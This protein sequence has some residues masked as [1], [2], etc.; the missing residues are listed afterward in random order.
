MPKVLLSDDILEQLARQEFK[1]YEALKI[2]PP[3]VQ[4]QLDYPSVPNMAVGHSIVA[5]LW[6]KFPGSTSERVCRI[7][8]VAGFNNTPRIFNDAA[9]GGLD[10]M[11][12]RSCGLA[13]LIVGEFGASELARVERMHLYAHVSSEFDQWGRRAITLAQLDDHDPASD[14]QV[15]VA[16][17]TALFDSYQMKVKPHYLGTMFADAFEAKLKTHILTVLKNGPKIYFAIIRQLEVATPPPLP[18]LQPPRWIVTPIW[19]LW[20]DWMRSWLR[21]PQL[22]GTRRRR[23]R[24]Q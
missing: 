4:L 3:H 2:L 15:M 24:T 9:A 22:R 6:Q 16:Q 10:P 8:S 23:R 13:S 21:K 14:D 11:G 19:C 7:L 1:D 12:T 5:D 17:L 18:Q 20:R